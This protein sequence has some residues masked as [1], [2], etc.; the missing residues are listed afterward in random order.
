MAIRRPGVAA[1]LTA[2]L[3][4]AAACGSTV[5]IEQQ[6]AAEAAAARGVDGSFGAGGG[7]GLGTGSG[8]GSAVGGPGAGVSGGGSG[9]AIG[10]AGAG[11]SGGSAATGAGG[12]ASGANGPG[13]TSS[14]IKL[15][16][17]F[18][19]DGQETNTALGGAGATQIDFR[20]AYDGMIEWVNAR[21]GIAGR[22]AVPVYD[23]LQT[24][25]SQTQDQQ[26]QETCARF[27]ED[28]PVFAA[29][30]GW[31]TEN[32]I[33]CLEKAGLVVVESNSL[34]FRS[35]AFFQRHPYYIEFDGIDNDDISTLTVDSL[36]KEKFFS[37]S[38][39]IGIVTWDNP[40]YAG[41][42][43]Q[44]LIP[45]L[46]K[47]GLTPTDVAY[48]KYPSSQN[49]YGEMAAQ[50]G[51]AAVT[52][53]SEG[54]THVMFLDQGALIAFFFMQAA[55]RQQYRPRYGLNSGSGGTTLAGLLRSGGDN[56]ARNQLHGSVGVGWV[57]TIDVGP[58]DTPGW[59]DT[60]ARKLCY[61]IMNK[62]GVSMTSA[63]A[64]AQAEGVCNTIWTM[65]GTLSATGSVINQDTY[66]AGLDRVGPNDVD[67]TW[68]TGFAISS[69]RHDGNK[70]AAL[71]K[72]YD[73]CVCFRYTS[74]P[75]AVPD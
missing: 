20:R 4:V 65:D 13:I 27:T 18:P 44:T 60:Q 11:G 16:F 35:N 59:A 22:K 9:S 61:S 33:S 75:F 62:N 41:P 24:A 70:N 58:D 51:N 74:A 72:F 56:D 55:E 17:S 45:R 31:R 8:S 26:D 37:K 46:K 30:A 39:K 52:F 68:G 69:T 54:I 28:D 19:T 53:K 29:N 57:P 23:G 71:M 38:A 6:Q 64:R 63:N 3:V 12:A 66:I 25:S 73:Q 32:G 34:V 40:E 7:D 2:S 36:V 15:G 1:L 43:Q 14:E 47:Y 5:P 21:G 10:S 67:L 50:I 49:D 48:V 42:V